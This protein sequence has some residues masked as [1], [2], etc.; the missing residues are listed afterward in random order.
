M[1]T[2]FFLL[3]LG[4]I[5]HKFWKTYKPSFLCES[6][7]CFGLANTP[8]TVQADRHIYVIIM[9]ASTGKFIPIQAF[10][11]DVM[12]A[13]EENHRNVFLLALFSAYCPQ[14]CRL[15]KKSLSTLH[16]LNS[17]LWFIAWTFRCRFASFPWL[18]CV[19]L[20]S[21]QG[22]WSWKIFVYSWT[23]M[24]WNGDAVQNSFCVARW[25]KGQKFLCWW[26]RFWKVVLRKRKCFLCSVEMLPSTRK[27]DIKTLSNLEFWCFISRQQTEYWHS[28]KEQRIS[29][30][31]ETS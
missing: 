18:N 6:T 24:P 19:W 27:M 5:D 13:V 11:Q 12:T 4:Q 15:P 21:R 20:M 7:G 26:Q 9:A 2:L 17:F 1:M 31:K 25:L 8:D 3:K 28:P 22:G 23:S 10:I 14:Y 29:Y 16:F 30:W